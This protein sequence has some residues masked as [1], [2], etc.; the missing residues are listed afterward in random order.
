MPKDSQPDPK[1]VRKAKAN[2]QT[3]LTRENQNHNRNAKKKLS[4]NN[5]S[6]RQEVR[7][8]ISQNRKGKGTGKRNLSDETRQLMS[9]HNCMHNKDVVDKV[10]N[11][12]IG[13]HHT[14]ETKQLLKT[15]MKE[16][17]NTAEAKHKFSE[18]QI[19]HPQQWNITI[20]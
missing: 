6:H 2:G 17:C 18:W 8:K 13:H 3:P 15:K 10:R 1:E 7:D 20:H 4:Q 16:I 19:E 9:D 5:G 14:E 12:I 11:K